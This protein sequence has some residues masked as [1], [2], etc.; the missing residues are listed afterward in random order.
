MILLMQLSKISK[1]T[2]LI[3]IC[4]AYVPIRVFMFKPVIH[5]PT[6]LKVKFQYLESWPVKCLT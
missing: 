5:N 3:N 6:V 2:L 4:G 1:L